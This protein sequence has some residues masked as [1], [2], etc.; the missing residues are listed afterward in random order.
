MSCQTLIK[1]KQHR[2]KI[3][4]CLLCMESA[5]DV[6]IL[7]QDFLDDTGVAVD[8]VLEREE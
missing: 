7:V 1:T 8:D 5:H 3:R 2:M 6:E 4:H